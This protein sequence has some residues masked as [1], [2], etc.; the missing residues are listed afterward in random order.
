MDTVV[1]A[2]SSCLLASYASSFVTPSMKIF[3]EL[4]H[5]TQRHAQ[6]HHRFSHFN[7][8]DISRE[9]ALCVV[10]LAI[11]CSSCELCVCLGFDVLSDVLGEVHGDVPSER[12]KVE[13][14]T[15][16]ESS[17]DGF[18]EQV[19]KGCSCVKTVSS[20]AAGWDLCMRA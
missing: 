15:Q 4:S 5:L 8:D 2:S 20:G 11:V 14:L 1:P 6:S 12:W 9:L 16:G 18:I 19:W 7:V 17:K 13:A 3:S 10:E